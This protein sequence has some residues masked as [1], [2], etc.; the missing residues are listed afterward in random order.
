MACLASRLHSG[1]P[2]VRAK[3]DPVAARSRRN[4]GCQRSRLCWVWL[5][6]GAVIGFDSAA[7]RKS[8]AMNATVNSAE[9]AVLDWLAQRQV[10]MVELIEALVNIDSGSA[11][12]SGVDAVGER[13]I[14]FLGDHGIRC[15][16]IP[17]ERYGN[18]LR[19][20][21]GGGPGRPIVLM[22]HR[23]TVFPRGEAERRR[24]H[25]ADGRGHGPGCADMKSGLVM[26]AFVLAALQACSGA[27]GPV[28][29]LFTGDEEIGSPFSRPVIE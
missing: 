27:A 12:K 20:R 4:G 26:N 9:R 28:V 25:V 15:D 7:M 23:D 10:A 8:G 1:A 11:D 22:G 21:V 5:S 2:N 16:V 24:F 14:R 19:A 6:N 29:G 18:A 17:S 13:I 3:L